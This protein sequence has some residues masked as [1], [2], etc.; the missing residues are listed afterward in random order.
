MRERQRRVDFTNSWMF[1]RVMTDESICRDVIRAV[2]GIEAVRIDYLNAEQVLD[3][4][5]E[6]HGVRMDVYAR[7][8]GSG[9]RVYDLEMQAQR[10]PLLGKRFRYYQAVLDVRELPAG[11]DYDRLPE[12]F[13][14]FLCSQD[15]F[16]Y[17]LP[18]YHL[19]RRC[20]EVPELR[21]GNASHWLALNARAWEDAPGGDLL[22]PLQCCPDGQGP[23]FA[24]AQDRGG[25]RAGQRG[26][27]VGGQ[28]VVGEHDR[29][30]RRAARAHKRPHR[31]RGGARGRPPRRP[32]RRPR[33]GLRA[34]RRPGVPAH[35]G[36][37]RRRS[38]ASGIR[39]RPARRALSGVR[40]VGQSC[41]Y[42]A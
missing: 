2:L 18:V 32:P 4:A 38:R 5:P 16:G 35:R 41:P 28:G 17:D 26:S 34:V 13:V 6:S 10:E 39:S 15:P 7:E 12:S 33:G 31:L 19:E 22:D 8:R 30:E 20:D 37:P 3:P 40:S 9:E 42:A 11:D 36:R 27:R 14:V 25:G 21:L 29:G 1:G 23:G 24:L